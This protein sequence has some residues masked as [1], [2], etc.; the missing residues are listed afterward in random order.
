MAVLEGLGV[1]EGTGFEACDSAGGVG[2]AGR[3]RVLRRV[4]ELPAGGA[5]TA[6]SNGNCWREQNVLEGQRVLKRLRVLER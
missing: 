5:G 3:G 1:L 2:T 6:G 4:V